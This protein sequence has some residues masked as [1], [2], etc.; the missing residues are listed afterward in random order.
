MIARGSL[1]NTGAERAS[2]HL[3]GLPMKV[4]DTW[5]VDPSWGPCKHAQLKVC[6]NPT[7]KHQW[8]FSG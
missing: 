7:V 6:K 2:R 1:L 3:F 4:F 8:V 5:G